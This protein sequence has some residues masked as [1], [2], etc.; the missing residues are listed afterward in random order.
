VFDM[1]NLKKK[2]VY[3]YIT[4]SQ[5]DIPGLIDYILI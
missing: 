3:I 4:Y 2:T 1:G 5:P